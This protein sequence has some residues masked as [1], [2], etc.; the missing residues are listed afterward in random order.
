MVLFFIVYETW[1]EDEL[2]K[3]LMDEPPYELVSTIKEEDLHQSKKIEP[4]P[5]KRPSKGKFSQA[6]K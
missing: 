6:K 3:L 5:A 2:S 4:N 1:M